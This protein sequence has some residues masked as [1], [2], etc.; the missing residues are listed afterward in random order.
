MRDRPRTASTA[1]ARP[2]GATAR[3]DAAEASARSRDPR[4]R[5]GD[6]AGDD[7][8]DDDE[9]DDDEADDDEAGRGS[10]GGAPLTPAELGVAPT[11]A[12]DA[13]AR[14]RPALPSL[15]LD[16]A[17]A[18]AE[19]ALFG[20]AEAVKIGR[21]R[22]IERAGAGGMG[23]VW[24][25]WDPELGRGVALKLASSGDTAARERARDEGRAL[26]RLSHPNVVPIY[27]VLEHPDGVFLVMELVKGQ[28]L[29]S[30]AASQRAPQIIRAYRQAG[31]G[32]A[33]AHKAGLIHRDFKPDNA[34]LGAD[35][36][37]RVLDFGLAHEVS[38]DDDT[39]SPAVAG[40]PRYMAPEQRAGAALTP[41]VDQFG[42]CIALR[43]SLITAGGVPRW[44]AP[45]LARGTADD[46]GDRFPS[47]DALLHAL[48]LD[49]RT[50]WRRRITAGIAAF[51]VAGAVGGFT[52]GRAHSAHETPC[53][54]G[55]ELVAPSWGP[56]R[57][58]AIAAHLQALPGAFGAQSVPRVLAAIDAYRDRWLALH[59]GSCVVH[60][61]GELSSDLFDRRTACLAR[62]L[63]S[64]QAIGDRAAATTAAALPGLVEAVDQLDEIAACADDD[65][66]TADVPPPPAGLAASTRPIDDA[67]A[68]AAVAR[69]AGRLDEA[70]HEADG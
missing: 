18:K 19:A 20:T 64:L 65:A 24:S 21:Y 6:D 44:V 59:R 40:T 54:G 39:G 25:A 48:A 42:L 33:A 3:A 37:V 22:V 51:A 41:A 10:R 56:A 67:L 35:G 7:E 11:V 36:R 29:R 4:A 46:P 26:A 55:P 30:A 60:R 62:R 15:E 38:P 17:M 50:R 1:P 8:A 66:L 63:A 31:E 45:I 52:L 58:A 43:E 68:R 53:A 13:V 69:D 9:A 47:M 16:V 12:E 32:L 28:T 34:I 14:A 70:R 2:G 57:R 27:D 61:R 5:A 23:V 49:P